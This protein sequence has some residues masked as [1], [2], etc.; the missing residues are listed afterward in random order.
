[1]ND[2]L[3]H[4]QPPSD[5][6]IMRE[7]LTER[8]AE[9]LARQTQLLESVERVP[10]EIADEETSGKVGDLIKMIRAC[11]SSLDKVRIAEKEPFLTME[12]AVDG[13]FNPLI[14]N[15]DSKRGGAKQKLE[16]LVGA[17]LQKK[18]AE[19]QRRRDEEASRLRAEAA[20]RTAEA[21]RLEQEQ[22]AARQ[23]ATDAEAAQMDNLAATNHA[24][25]DT[26]GQQVEQKVTEAIVTE[27]LATKAAEDAQARPSQMAVSHGMAG[28]RSSLRTTKVASIVSRQELNTQLGVIGPHFTEAHLMVAITSW[29]KANWTDDKN[30]PTLAG[31]S[32]TLEASAQV[33]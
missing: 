29:M 22:A 13:F 20:A 3:G 12:R 7:K 27:K 16:R 15:L 14:E 31:V 21:L 18:A 17:F 8:N 5:A 25:A 19:E 33:R 32:F 28:S 24:Q 1:M 9:L 11:A 26:L 30:P 6:E 23:A 10:N 4:N 2:M